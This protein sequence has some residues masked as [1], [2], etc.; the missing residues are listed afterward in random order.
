MLLLPYLITCTADMKFTFNFVGLILAFA[1]SGVVSGHPGLPQ[2][3]CSAEYAYPC[4]CP[5]GKFYYETTTLAIIGSTIVE[6]E[7][8]LNDFYATAWYG[9]SDP[10]STKGP[11]NKPGSIRTFNS[12]A[13]NFSEL[14]T[15]YIVRRDHSFLQSYQEYEDPKTA[16]K[17]WSPGFF[18]TMEGRGL[19]QNETE[20]SLRAHGCW[21]GT[22]PDFTSSHEA[23]LANAISIL[24]AKGKAFLS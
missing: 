22:M 20:I 9:G 3:A 24:G 4:A 5:L 1:T 2:P 8:F 17:G 6:S 15:E 18:V 7:A 12:P 16:P 14:L 21:S 13:N 11:D 23:G 10:S 19:F